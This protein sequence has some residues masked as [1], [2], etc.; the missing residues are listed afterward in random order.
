MK[1]AICQAG[2]MPFQEEALESYFKY[3]Q[4]ESLVIFGE[5][6]FDLFFSDLKQKPKEMIAQ[7]SLQKILSLQKMAKRYKLKIVVP[8]VV[9]DEKCKLYKKIAV[10]DAKTTEY[11]MQQRLINYDHWNEEKFYSNPKKS[12]K[13]PYIF[14]FCGATIGVLFGFESHFDALWLKMQEQNVDI[15]LVPTA[16]TFEST[17]RWQMLLQMRAFCSGMM[18]VRV[19]RTGSSM[20]ENENIDFYGDSFIVDPDAQIVEKMGNK[21]GIVC[22]EFDLKTI[23]EQAKVWGFKRI[24][25]KRNKL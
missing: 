19:N 7:L 4:K 25:N 22:Y 14:D 21:E 3:I 6:V 5:Y 20:L 13:T 15:V 9:A 18:V 12:F 10:I 2:S 1:I 24:K 23:R 16:S 17:K 8:I 11:Y